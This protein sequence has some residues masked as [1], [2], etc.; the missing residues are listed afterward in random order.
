MWFGLIM[1]IL[2]VPIM[3]FCA[4]FGMNIAS[5]KIKKDNLNNN[6]EIIKN[7]NFLIKCKVCGNQISKNASTCPHCGEPSENIKEKQ[8][9]DEKS[10]QILGIV[11]GIIMLILGIMMM[12]DGN[13]KLLNSD[14][15]YDDSDIYYDSKND[16]YTIQL[17]KDDSWK[18]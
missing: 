16:T 2:T 12:L 15:D 6:I 1:A 3:L 11:I 9:E 7:E 10:K 13:S 4:G 17:Y 5:K 8:K 14:E 18:Y